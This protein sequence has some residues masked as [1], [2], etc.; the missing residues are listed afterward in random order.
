[1]NQEWVDYVSTPTN[2]SDK[3]YGAQFW[4]NA[5]CELPDVPT[6]MYFADGFQGQRVFIL[7]TKDLVI[8]RT[9]LTNIDY[10]QLLKGILGSIE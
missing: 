9:G 4:L 3:K 7:P 8:V 10:N 2:G 1:M 5:G 6:T